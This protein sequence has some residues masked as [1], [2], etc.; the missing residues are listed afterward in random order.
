M[1][2]AMSAV[3]T[4]PDGTSTMEVITNGARGSQRIATS[5]AEALL[6]RNLEVA[7]RSSDWGDLTFY[8]RTT[9]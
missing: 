6:G 1:L 4:L 5:V 7:H 8:F 2:E 9:H 3:T